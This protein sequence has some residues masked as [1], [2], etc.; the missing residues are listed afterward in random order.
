MQPSSPQS[1]AIGGPTPTPSLHNTLAVTGYPLAVVGI[2]TGRM[3]E[4]AAGTTRHP[5]AT[6][7][8]MGVLTVTAGAVDVISFLALGQVFT[9]LETGNVLFLA[10]SLAGMGSIPAWR[11]AV[12]L[13]A[14]TVGA[15]LGSVTIRAMGRRRWFPVVLAVEAMLLAG[16]GLV[17]LH[18]G[19]GSPIVSPH[20][21]VIS[22]VAVAMGLQ[23]VAALRA[24]IPGMST[25][26]IQISLVT[27]VNTVLSRPPRNGGQP[28]P[29]ATW[30]LT[31]RRHLVTVGGIFV[32]GLLGATL[33][34]WGSG[35]ALLVL[36]S[37]LLVSAAVWGLAAR[38]RLEA[39]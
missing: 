17:A 33:T 38:Y 30:D 11:P 32:G 23:S 28:R 19:V 22:L 24:R 18:V 36:A 25:Q 39:T 21:V 16:A 13:A 15:A 2:E 34:R 12:A 3:S 31:H 37:A 10:F 29:T 26:L 9:A 4:N 27:L 6:T 5:L 14:F 35:W 20:P 1:A 7:A 8:A